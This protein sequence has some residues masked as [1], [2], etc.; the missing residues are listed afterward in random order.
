MFNYCVIIV[1]YRKKNQNK[2]GKVQR[3]LSKSYVIIFRIW[4]FIEFT[5]LTRHRKFVR[6]FYDTYT[7]RTR[8][9]LL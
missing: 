7:F 6:N 5:M 8:N 3:D 2:Q 4:Y 9:I 1:N